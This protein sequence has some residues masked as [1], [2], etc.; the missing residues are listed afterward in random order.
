MIKNILKE[1]WII[2]EIIIFESKIKIKAKKKHSNNETNQIKYIITETFYIF[3]HFRNTRY[4]RIVAHCHLKQRFFFCK[5]LEADGRNIWRQVN[6]PVSWQP[7]TRF[8][9]Q[10]S[11]K[12]RKGRGK[13]VE[14]M[15][16]EGG[17]RRWIGEVDATS[18]TKF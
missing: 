17:R 8:S 11:S 1:N 13:T 12:M 15:R 5:N 14:E 7:A 3:P 10:I 2:G 16:R 6:M 18:I 4:L 9:F